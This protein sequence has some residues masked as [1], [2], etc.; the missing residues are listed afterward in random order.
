MTVSTTGADAHPW[1]KEPE[2][3]SER[4]ADLAQALHPLSDIRRGIYPF[5][6]MRLSRAD[7]E[8]LLATHEGGRG[9]VAWADAES[10]PR[11]GL[12]LRGAILSGA[13]LSNLP[14][15]RLIG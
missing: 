4:Q 10:R 7:I 3:S 12:D 13:D 9:P 6:G 11:A 2:I 14:L 8:W 5:K 15:T 1:R